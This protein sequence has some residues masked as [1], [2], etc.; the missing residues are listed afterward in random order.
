LACGKATSQTLWVTAIR[1]KHDVSGNSS[2]RKRIGRNALWFF[3]TDF[4]LNTAGKRGN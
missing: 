2:R 1:T 4:E 3:V